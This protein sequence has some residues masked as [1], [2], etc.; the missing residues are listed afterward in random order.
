LNNNCY[1]NAVWSG[2]TYT[3]S[4]YYDGYLNNGNFNGPHSGNNSAAVSVRCV[5]D[6]DFS[7]KKEILQTSSVTGIQVTAP[8][9]ATDTQAAARAQTVTIATQTSCGQVRLLTHLHAATIVI[10]TVI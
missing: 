1:P 7:K 8:C 10:M 5:P 4:T 3:G 9:S 2:S 6:L